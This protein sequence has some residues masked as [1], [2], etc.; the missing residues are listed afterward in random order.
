MLGH[1]KKMWGGSVEMEK[2]KCTCPVLPSAR[3]AQDLIDGKEGAGLNVGRDILGRAAI[4]FAGMQLGRLV[5]AYPKQ[6]AIPAALLGSIAIELFAIAYIKA[7][8]PP[9]QESQKQDFSI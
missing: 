4:I 7:T 2:N 6:N 5:D 8:Q 9:P 1:I 3:S